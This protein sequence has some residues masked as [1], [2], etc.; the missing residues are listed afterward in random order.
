[1]APLAFNHSMAKIYPL[2][3]LIFATIVS[4]LSVGC[5]QRTLSSA[6]DAYQPVSCAPMADSL[7]PES[8]ILALENNIAHLRAGHGPASYTFGKR[9]VARADYV[10]GLERFR[11]HV[12]SAGLDPHTLN[13]MIQRDF[14][15]YEVFGRKKTG[16]VLVT[17]YFDP[18]IAASKTKT[19]THTIPIY[20]LP[21][22]MVMIQ[23]DAYF[24][25]FP[26]LA[27]KMTAKSEQKTPF[28]T[29]RGRLTPAKTPGEP[30]VI[31]PYYDRYELDVE[32]A[33]SGQKLEIA[34][35]DAIDAFFLHIQGSGV[36]EFANGRRQRV[37]YSAQNGHRYEALGKHLLEHIPLEK[38]SLQAIDQHLRTLP[39][40]ERLRVMSLNPS[41]VF[42]RELDSLS[43]GYLGTE[44]TAGRTIATDAR[45]FPKGTLGYLDVPAPQFASGQDSV[46][47]SWHPQ[48]RFVLDQ[49]TGGAIRGGGRV[50]L[51]WGEGPSAKQAAGVMKENGRLVYLVPKS[52]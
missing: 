40:E 13:E 6:Q 19:S 45:F 51:Y 43:I 21:K 20:R 28:A 1:M 15:C 39:M 31:V 2:V 38:M 12:K 25:T 50:D 23:L 27:A 22:D 37:G 46:P 16:E 24:K 44:V 41:Y 17:A 30:A 18:V 7:A 26:D 48:P 8:L 47:S 5:A 11:D 4:A 10:T 3:L 32:N 14:E 33:L 42:F 36:L 29:L 34:W 35:V 9:T 49:D 52:P